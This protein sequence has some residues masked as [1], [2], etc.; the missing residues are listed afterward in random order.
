MFPI[1]PQP[2][3]FGSHGLFLCQDPDLRSKIL[4][5]FRFDPTIAEDRPIG[6]GTTF[7]IDPWGRC[8]TAFHVVEELFRPPSAA[9]GV[10]SLSLYDHIRLAA[11]EINGIGFGIY[12]L[13]ENA[14]RPISDAHS[15]F[16]IE[17]PPFQEPRF[18]N[19][20]ELMALHIQPSEQSG[21]GA[22]FLPV[23]L[24]SWYPQ[25]GEHVMALGFADLDVD[26]DGAG[27][28]RP[29]SQYMYGSIAKIVDI[30]HADGA[31]GRPWPQFRVEAEWPGGMSG[32]P[33]FNEEG[34]VIGVVSAGIQ[35]QRRAS[36]TYFSG[37]DMP[38]RIFGSLDP[39]NPGWFR[40]HAVFDATGKLVRFSDQEAMIRQYARSADLTDIGH[41]SYDFFSG[42]W[43]RHSDSQR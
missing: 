15:I 13:P 35:G 29:I 17:T 19:I 28:H 1:E 39:N 4:P 6:Q 7:R 11:L 24:N 32:G 30:E 25:I 23:A 26:Q 9:T 12:A 3:E 41:A 36:A 43:M 33:V 10:T 16:G 34:N 42:G 14:W 22:P 20:T 40:G 38:E 8:A 18:R 37:W 31:R 21:Q 27:D 2:D 5:L